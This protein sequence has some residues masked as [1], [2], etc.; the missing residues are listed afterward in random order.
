M[1]SGADVSL[2]AVTVFG[3]V[4]V[5]SLNA[6]NSIFTGQVMAKRTQQG[7]VRFSYLP[8]A[9]TAP[10]RYRCQPEMALAGIDDPMERDTKGSRVAPFFRSM[11]YG[12]PGY[13]QLDPAGAAE[14]LEGAEDGSEMGA[15]GILKGSLRISDLETALDE[16]LRF[17]MDAGIFYED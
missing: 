4:D 10:R 13:A 8:E 14:I 3:S 15:L 17:G 9:S 1:A 6:D 2:Q 16:Y 11:T 12:R 5:L 7:C